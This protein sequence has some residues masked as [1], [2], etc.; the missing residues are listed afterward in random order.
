MRDLKRFH[1]YSVSE[2][3]GMYPFERDSVLV[4]MILSEKL[5]DADV[6]DQGWSK[7][8]A[9]VGATK[10]VPYRDKFTVLDE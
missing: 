8:A 4:P 1:Q 2:Q 6:P 7:Y 5:K 9:E 3:E 10:S